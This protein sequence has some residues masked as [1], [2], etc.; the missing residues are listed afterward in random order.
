MNIGDEIFIN[1]GKEIIYNRFDNNRILVGSTFQIN[2]NLNLSFIYNYQLGQRNNK[3]AYEHSDIF[4]LG[5]N[6][7]I[8]L[9][10][11]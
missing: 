3:A 10:H 11:D 6:Q 4:W 5:I 1:A 9:K 2:K 8:S 7:I